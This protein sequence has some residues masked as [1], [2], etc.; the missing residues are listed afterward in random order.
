MHKQ[1]LFVYGTLK[2][3]FIRNSALE[4]Q[5]YLGIACSQQKYGMYAFGSFPV[6]VDQELAD[7][8]KI[9]ANSKIY[10]ELYEVDNHCMSTIDKIE[11]VEFGLFK[12]GT[13][14]LDT[15]TL[16]SL[17]LAHGTW[18]SLESKIATVYFFCRQL[19]VAENCGNFY[20]L[21]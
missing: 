18:S 11:G 9:E 4:K 19:N 17:P 12:R 15:I 20:A 13:I 10:G 2:Q 14:E 21:K 7:K 8:W 3:G 16:S 6:L 5:R 1:L